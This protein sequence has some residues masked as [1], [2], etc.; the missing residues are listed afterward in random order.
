VRAACERFRPE[1]RGSGFEADRDALRRRV[2]DPLGL[3]NEVRRVLVS[4]DGALCYVPF[5]L[6][7]P[8]RDVVFVPSGTVYVRLAERGAGR[9]DGVLALGDPDY[10]ARPPSPGALVLRSGAS[11]APLPATRDEAKAVGDVVLLGSEATEAGLRSAL[12]GRP[13]WRGVHLACHGLVDTARPSL[14]AL[15]LTPTDADDGLLTALDVFQLDVGADLV[16]LSACETARGAVVRGEGLVGL[17]R[18]FLSAGASRVLSALWKVDDDATQALMRRFY[19]LWNPRDGSPA[20]PAG[21]ALRRAQDFVRT[22]P[23]HPSWRHPAHW[24]AWV[25]WGLPER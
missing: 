12:P 11:L 23:D 17:T 14:S 10:A 18:A 1:K 21:E 13:R 3:G 25:L 5:P 20:L 15:A 9:G 16:V 7:D 2:V 4:P 22:H 8:A 24:A 6:L 19:A